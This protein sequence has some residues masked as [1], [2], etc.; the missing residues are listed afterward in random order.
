MATA[1]PGPAPSGYPR[2]SLRGSP[3]TRRVDW[4]ARATARGLAI[5]EICSKPHQQ[6]RL[7]NLRTP[8]GPSNGA[9]VLVPVGWQANEARGIPPVLPEFDENE[10]TWEGLRELEA[11]NQAEAG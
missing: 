10:S 8:G 3:F 2:A 9:P 7:C 1:D 6:R 4:K 5:T 11:K